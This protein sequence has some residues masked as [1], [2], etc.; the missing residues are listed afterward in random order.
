MLEQSSYNTIPVDVRSK[1][2]HQAVVAHPL[3]EQPENHNAATL[4]MNLPPG[5]SHLKSNLKDCSK[6]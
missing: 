6:K 1:P 3:L 4:P 2:R 5:L